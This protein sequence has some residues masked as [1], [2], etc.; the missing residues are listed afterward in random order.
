MSITTLAMK[1]RVATY[2]FI[3]L[4]CFFGTFAYFYS[5]KAED[6]GYTIKTAV[7]TTNWPGATA[8]QMGELV[9]KQIEDEVRSLDSLDFVESKNLPGQSNVYV[10]LKA[11]YWNPDPEWTKLR[12]KIEFVIPKLP[13]GSQKPIINTY[14]GDVYGTVASISSSDLSY[15]ELYKK[16][17]EL[18]TLLLFKV[19]EIGQ[20]QITGAQQDVIYVEINNEK[21]ATMGISL[22]QISQSLK[23]A[24]IIIGGGSTA[25]SGNQIIVNPSGTFKTVEDLGKVVLA[26]KTKEQRIYLQEI[27][28]IYKGYVNP[29][30]LLTFNGEDKSIVLAM[31]L[32]A[33][34]N[35]LK[36]GEKTSAVL[37]SYE[38]TLPL[39]T[40]VK[41]VYNQSKFVDGK[42]AGFLSSL[43]QAIVVIVLIM[44]AFLGWRSG[45]IV[46]SLTPTTIA[47]TLIGLYILGYGINQMTLA[48]LIIALG[49][50]VDNAIVMAENVMVLS[51][52]GKSKYDACVESAKL[53]AIPLFTGSMTTAAAFLPVITNRQSMGQY[54]GPMAIVVFIALTASWLI[55]QTF[56]PLLCYDFLDV[57]NNKKVDYN[58]DKM[59]VGYRRLL[60]LALKNRTI[61]VGL[62][63]MSFVVGIFL[64]KFIP[65]S[66][67]P[68]G[69][70][71]VM[72]SYI[73]MPKGTSIEKTTEVVKDL[74]K[75]IK[76]KYYVGNIKPNPPG[77]MDYILTGGTTIT[78][79]KEG[80]LNWQSYVGGGGPRYTLGYTPEVPL[81]EFAYVL[82]SV[83]SRSLTERYSYE[84]NS[85]LQSKYPD[86]ALTSKSL[87]EG[88]TSEF[89]L[90]Y[91]FISPD[92]EKIKEVVE[93]VKKKITE[94][95]GIRLVKDNWGSYVPQIE[96]E[97]DY[98]KAILAGLTT[99]DVGNAI[100]YSLEGFNATVFYDFN[101]PPKNTSI[102]VKIKGTRNYENK[103]DSLKELEITNNNGEGVP[104]QQVANL[105]LI[106]VPIFVNTRD[107]NYAIQVEAGI[108]NGYTAND[109]NAILQPWI[110][111]K[112]NTDWKDKGVQFKIAGQM[113]TSQE[114][115]AGLGA[116]VPIALLIMLTLVIAQFNSFKK[117]IIVMLTIPL[118]LLGCSLGLLITGLDFG[119]MGIVGVISLAGVVL[120]HA[121]VLIDKITIE[122]EDMKRDDQN[123]IVIGCQTRLRPILLTVFTTLAGLLPLFFFGGPMFKPL[124]AVLIFGL[125]VDTV[126]SLGAIPV[127]YAVFFKINFKGYEYN[128]E[129]EID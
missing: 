13:Q 18:K 128:S 6:P 62:A 105:K 2:L 99:S 125:I 19:P 87:Q 57:T 89:D 127:I 106:Y 3:T 129:E 85:Y 93:E 120:N 80:I 67:M 24:N 116:G 78:Y 16:A 113:K 63:I 7:I 9:S 15:D 27:A 12:N 49:M 96:V 53:L 45:L 114:N 74:N 66:F 77:I 83:T 122:K 75:F 5:E 28:K 14:F 41:L 72:A 21:M 69:S 118:S 32:S 8:K 81:P 107:M 73:R 1:N 22:S 91:Q 48:G 112:I 26:G 25:D 42:I 55:N 84:I 126:L 101:A 23:N 65:S 121:I 51:Q 35:I 117:G 38:K 111:E 76:E 124:A 10:N 11:K 79:E 82:Y 60:I 59:Y 109:L 33:G 40:E 86:I 52:Q 37:E 4:I 50:L 68:E 47:V 54:V 98:N 56:I 90:S 64:F 17:E 102:P 110:V 39:G 58:K 108:E 44:F 103:L 61:S 71:P 30:S 36:L 104:L 94:T 46:A 100:Q 92:L 88:V 20:I 123:A 119:F 115:S 43:I 97:V 70:T 29:A 34:E 95:E 31:S